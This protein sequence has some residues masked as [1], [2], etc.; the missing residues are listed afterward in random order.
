MVEAFTPRA[1]DEKVQTAARR[2]AAT[3]TTDS[4][5]RLRHIGTIVVPVDET[6][7]YI[8]EA[9]T[10]EGL[11]AATER[12]GISSDR[13]VEARLLEPDDPHPNPRGR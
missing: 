11:R 7:F 2:A 12:A 1:E 10:L 9:E 6:C 4:G 13:I 8:F 3:A 5:R